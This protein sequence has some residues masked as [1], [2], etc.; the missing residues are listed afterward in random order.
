MFANS[1]NTLEFHIQGWPRVALTADLRID[2]SELP[3]V[4]EAPLHILKRLSAQAV[5]ENINLA[6][7]TRLY[8]K[9][10]VE[11]GKCAYV[12]G[13]SLKPSDDVLASLYIV[14]P[15]GVPNGTYR[16]AVTQVVNDL[17]M[18]RVSRILA[19]GQHPFLANRRSG[20]VHIASCVWAKKV[21]RG[22]KVAYQELE[23]A[24]KH[25]YNGCHSCL[26]DFDTG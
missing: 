11:T 16:V 4:A 6:E 17:E 7:E 2:L 23:H 18:G 24:I 20:E 19:V 13:M 15:E 12:R 21:G 25:G 9:F 14:I 22:N 3:P 1:T 26:T 5:F 8:Q 10:Q